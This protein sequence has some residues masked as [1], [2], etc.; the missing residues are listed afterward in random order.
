MVN[1]IA[2]YLKPRP[3]DETAQGLRCAQAAVRVRTGEFLETIEGSVRK[4]PG[5]WLA[6]AFALGV[7]A[8]WWTKR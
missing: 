7:A 6:A 3:E 1:R 2:E 5:Q 8:A 4:H